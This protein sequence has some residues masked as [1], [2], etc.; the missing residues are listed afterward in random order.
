M[1]AFF[2]QVG[3]VRF[4]SLVPGAPPE[5]LGQANAAILANIEAGK[6]MKEAARAKAKAR[7]VGPVAKPAMVAS[8]QPLPTPS[9][10]RTLADLPTKRWQAGGGKKTQTAKPVADRPG[11]GLGRF[12]L[13]KKGRERELQEMQRQA[14]L[15]TLSRVANR[16]AAQDQ[17]LEMDGHDMARCGDAF[18]RG[19]IPLG[20]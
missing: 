3:G 18:E 6:R 5:V 7:K 4:V 13:S 14:R 2:E 19:I 12:G 15:V 10:P 11:Q 17:L 1:P 8:A 9:R 20:G 16:L